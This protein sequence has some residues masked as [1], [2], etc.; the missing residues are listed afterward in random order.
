[1][2]PIIA[3]LTSKGSVYDIPMKNDEFIFSNNEYIG[4]TKAMS[5]STYIPPN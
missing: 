2:H 5:V 1:M 4:L 3:L